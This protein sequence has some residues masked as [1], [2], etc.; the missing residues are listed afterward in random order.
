MFCSKPVNAPSIDGSG[1]VIIHF[2]LGV[3]LIVHAGPD[4]K[5]AHRSQYKCH[6]PA[7]LAHSENKYIFFILILM[8]KRSLGLCGLDPVKKYKNI[9]FAEVRIES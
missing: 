1:Q 2:L 7:C 3:L 4:T 5:S 8:K 6:V 9:P